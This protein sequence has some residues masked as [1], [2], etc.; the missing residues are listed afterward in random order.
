MSIDVSMSRPTLQMAAG[1]VAAEAASPM[2][3]LRSVRKSYGNL[4]VVKDVSLS[5]GRGEFVSVL[6]P[7][8]SGK[9]TILMAI[10]GF[11]GLSGGSIHLGG[12]NVTDTAPHRRNIGMVYQHY[13]LFPHMQVDKN[14]AFP[15]AMRGVPAE[16]I[17]KKVANALEIVQLS[18]MAHRYPSELSGGQQQRIALARALVF[19]PT[20]LLMDEPLG[21]LDNKLREDMQREIRKIQQELD[22]TTLY[23][24]HDQNEALTMSDRVVVMSNGRI[25]QAGTPKEVYEKPANS[26]VANFIGDAN[27]IDVK[28]SDS[29]ARLGSTQAGTLV[30]LPELNGLTQGTACKAM[31]R[32]EHVRVSRLNGDGKDKGLRGSILYATYIG[33]AWRYS[34]QLESGECLIAVVTNDQ[35]GPVPVSTDVVVSWDPRHVWLLRD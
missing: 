24:T 6:G 2:L 32:P 23:I 13:A 29:A 15:L 3:E 35:L 1:N 18:A 26:F 4:T 11:V 9:T 25:E 14:V 19:E 30:Q 31:I 20:M 33:T 10:A 16:T 27:L 5:V 17:K 8:G 28:I 12:R 22:I 21:A 34:V 7:S